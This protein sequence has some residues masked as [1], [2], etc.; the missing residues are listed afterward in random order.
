[1][2]SDNG[3]PSAS[4]T[5]HVIVNVLDANDNDPQFSRDSYQFSVEENMRRGAIIGIVTAADADIDANAAIR[6]SLIPSNTSF[7]VNPVTGEPTS[8]FSILLSVI[9]EVYV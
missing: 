1:M 2:A 7:Q 9:V 5:T 6:Y 3:T 4:A 8:L